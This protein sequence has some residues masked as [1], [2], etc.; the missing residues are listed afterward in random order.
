MNISRLTASVGGHTAA[1][2]VTRPGRDI[3]T[4]PTEATAHGP[5]TASRAT[6]GSGEGTGV[7]QRSSARV[8]AFEQSVEARFDQILKSGDLD[9]R[10]TQAV[11]QIKSQ[12][13][14]MLHRLDSAF[15]GADGLEGGA[16]NALQ[17]I[18]QLTG[19]ALESVLGPKGPGPVEPTEHAG[20]STGGID[21]VA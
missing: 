17:N 10:Q 6:E 11:E 9:P 8:A 18:L 16:Q 2:R 15:Y 4:S 20:N 19:G 1:G 12:F 21:T 7:V 14:S 13:S 5:E 3:E